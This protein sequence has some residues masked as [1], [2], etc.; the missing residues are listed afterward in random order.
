MAKSVEQR[1]KELVEPTTKVVL[2]ST[3]NDI[4]AE[5]GKDLGAPIFKKLGDI[6]GMCKRDNF[7]K[8]DKKRDDARKLLD[9]PNAT[10]AKL[11][12]QNAG[13]KQELVDIGND[14][15]GTLSLVKD[16]QK[17]ED[18]LNNWE[19]ALKSQ[20]EINKER[21]AITDKMAKVC[22]EYAKCQADGVS[23]IT[24]EVTA[25]K[26][27][28]TSTNN[29]LNTLESQIRT[30]DVAYQKTAIDM[31]KKEIADKVRSLLNCFGR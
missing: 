1:T 21:K 26:A 25:A 5:C 20:L 2:V 22:E 24:K 3:W 7:I 4:V 23:G 31:D 15:D 13:L 18:I 14:M 8:Y 29:E 6:A 30:A 27:L 11:A 12:K 9:T 16:A 17:I 28:M 19:E 10:M